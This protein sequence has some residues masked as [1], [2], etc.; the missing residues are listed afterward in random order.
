VVPG[1]RLACYGL[2]IEWHQFEEELLAVAER[3]GTIP[4]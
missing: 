4:K 2:K 1:T 3:H